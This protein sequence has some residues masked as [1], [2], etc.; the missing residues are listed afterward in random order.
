MVYIYLI[1]LPCRGVLQALGS[2]ASLEHPEVV[3]A[4][5]DDVNH[6]EDYPKEAHHHQQPKVQVHLHSEKEYCL[7]V[8]LLHYGQLDVVV[9]EDPAAEPHYEDRQEAIEYDKVA[10]PKWDPAYCE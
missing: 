1:L 10:I 2:I 6:V 4:G 3:K 5:G 9:D 8:L 7:L